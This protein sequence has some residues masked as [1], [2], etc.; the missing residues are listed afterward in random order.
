MIPRAIIGQPTSSA[1]VGSDLWHHGRR[2]WAE[3][4]ERMRRAMTVTAPALEAMRE[5]FRQAGVATADFRRAME[6]VNRIVN[7][8]TDAEELKRRIG[9][10]S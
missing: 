4:M 6:G 5:G 7:S 2:R 3:Q 9:G 10:A 8:G 1:F